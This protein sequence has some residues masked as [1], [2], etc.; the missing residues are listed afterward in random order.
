MVQ[1]SGKQGLNALLVVLITWFLITPAPS[2]AQDSARA[3]PASLLRRLAEVTDGQGIS[4]RVYIVARYA[5]PHEVLGVFQ[6]RVRADAVVARGQGLGLFGPFETTIPL[7]PKFFVGGCVHDGT[8][9]AY[10]ICPQR[11]AALPDVRSITLITRLQN[12]DSISVTYPGPTI[13]AVFFTLDAMD[14]FAF[15]YYTRLVGVEET[16]RMRADLVARLHD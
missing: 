5:F 6:D 1:A 14:K 16:A 3:L 8:K 4:G 13:D 10:G 15:P 7:P 9:S 12:G 2:A 11:T